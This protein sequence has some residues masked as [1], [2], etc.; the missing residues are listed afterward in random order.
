MLKTLAKSI[1][2]WDELFTDITN[3]LDLDS[4]INTN[5]IYPSINDIFKPFQLLKHKDVKVVFINS[6]PYLNNMA[7]GLAFSVSKTS[8]IPSSLS[9]MF[10]ELKSSYQLN[11]EYAKTARNII[12]NDEKPINI[13]LQHGDL[14]SWEKQGILLINKEFTFSKFHL[15]G[16]WEPFY[17]KLMRLLSKNKDILFVFFGKQS[18]E[19]TDL[20]LNNNN[21]VIKLSHPS[22]LAIHGNFIG[23]NIFLD[24]NLHLIKHNKLPI[25]WNLYSD[26]HYEKIYNMLDV[27]PISKVLYKIVL[28]YIHE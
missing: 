12:Y 7:N 3:E 11:T 10:K 19:N 8:K 9:N 5:E 20:L 16:I 26:E 2:G 21:K 28:E 13:E 25:D 27:I 22:P 18:A 24:I 1:V 17:T 4:I 15:F 23:S 6:S 14:S